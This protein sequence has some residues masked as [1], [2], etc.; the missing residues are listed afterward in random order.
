MPKGIYPHKKG[1]KREP[2]SEE[3]RK[4]MSIASLKV[5]AEG[6]GGGFKVGHKL[7]VGNK[8]LLG[9]KHTEEWKEKISQK[10]K[11]RKFTLGMRGKWH[12]SKE[13]K[14]KHRIVSLKQFANGMPEET[15]AKIREARLRQDC[16]GIKSVN[17]K[18]EIAVYGTKHSWVRRLKGKPNTCERCGKTILDG[19]KIHW[20]NID[21]KYRRNLDD[22]IRLCETCHAEYDVANGLRKHKKIILL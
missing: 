13:I 5:H 12:Q 17:W 10:F 21:H 15:K 3:T 6:R 2:I 19:K 9:R 7:G 1:F 22:Y 14:E 20:A 16:S 8:Y 18:G 11:G 4:R